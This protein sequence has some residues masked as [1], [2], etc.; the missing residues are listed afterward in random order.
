MT[1][2]SEIYIFTYKEDSLFLNMNEF[3][4]PSGTR[5]DSIFIT[6]IGYLNKRG[7]FLS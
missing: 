1:G 2:F 5:M 7:D 3:F 6:K 4:E